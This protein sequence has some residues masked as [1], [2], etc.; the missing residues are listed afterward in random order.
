MD[1]P[2]LLIKL[3]DRLSARAD[4]YGASDSDDA[5]AASWVLNCV[6]SELRDLADEL[7]DQSQRE[8]A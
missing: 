2:A 3:A 1:A 8:A 5:G 7:A 4:R 6:A